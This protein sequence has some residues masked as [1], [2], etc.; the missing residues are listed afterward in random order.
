MDLW[1]ACLEYPFTLSIA[2]N[3]IAETQCTNYMH[4]A[5]AFFGIAMSTGSFSHRRLTVCRLCKQVLRKT[6]MSA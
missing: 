4:V 2:R 3:H 6:S 5:K 1:T